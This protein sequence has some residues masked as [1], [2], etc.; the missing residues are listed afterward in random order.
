MNYHPNRYYNSRPFIKTLLSI[1]RQNAGSGLPTMEVLNAISNSYVQFYNSAILELPLEDR[2]SSASF[3]T[4]E[5]SLFMHYANFYRNG[6]NIFHFQ[7]A[8]TTLLRQTEVDDVILDA[9]KLPYNAFYVHFGQQSDLNL[10]GQ[11]YFVDGAYVSTATTESSSIF[12]ILL[13][14]IRTDLDYSI[15]PNYIL[16]PDR[17]YYFPLNLTE[18]GIT[19]KTAINNSIAEHQPFTPKNLPDTT[20]TYVVDDRKVSV[21]DRGKFTSLEIAA[22][23]KQGFP[24]FL[25]AIKLVINGI[26]Y[27]SSQHQEINT[28]FPDNAPKG[29]LERLQRAQKPADIARTTR[30]LASMGYTKI[31]FCGDQIQRDLDSLP[32]GRE[33]STHWR[34]GHW[35]DQAHGVKY[36]ER[37]LLWIM[38]TIVRKDKGNPLIGHIYDVDSKDK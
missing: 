28:R 36:S 16:H 14:T 24:I 34:R 10:W 35:R 15:K 11:H 9:I 25:E 27:L 26:C 13:T 30:K 4:K 12:Q 8:L 38:P 19:V 18:K 17:Y 5:V 6:R 7:R 37:K 33:L 22:E 3:I 2:P 31:H 29:L 21:V 1:Y 20:G 32:T 23:K